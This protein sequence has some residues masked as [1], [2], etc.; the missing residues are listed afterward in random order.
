M[1]KDKNIEKVVK[2]LQNKIAQKKAVY[3]EMSYV[4]A[5]QTVADSIIPYKK[6]EFNNLPYVGE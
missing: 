6:G 2:N 3:M 1:N 4:K 5:I